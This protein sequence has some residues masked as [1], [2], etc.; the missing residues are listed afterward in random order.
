MSG[1]KQNARTGVDR[2]LKPHFDP[3]KQDVEAVREDVVSLVTEI[4]ERLGEIEADARAT[5]DE[6]RGV[7][8]STD[9]RLDHTNLRLHQILDEVGGVRDRV[10]RV[11][12]RFGEVEAS[13]VH[14]LEGQAKRQAEL[15]AGMNELRAAMGE[16]GTVTEKNTSAIERDIEAAGRA[17]KEAMEK[18][19]LLFMAQL[20]GLFRAVHDET[21]DL[22]SDI[23]ELTRMI[24]MQGDAADQVAEVMGRTFTRLSSEVGALSAAV[25][26]LG[27]GA[28]QAANA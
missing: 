20:E 14:Q 5:N 23:V 11:E 10:E 15:R 27:A 16:L 18:L 22:R 2:L 24:R 13:I 1:W 3:L 12:Q 6:L 21:A 4:R 7:R 8:G 17:T 9:T 25:R 28:Q 26:E 19:E